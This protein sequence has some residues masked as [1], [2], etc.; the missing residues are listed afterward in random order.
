M[1]SEESNQLTDNE[2]KNI[3]KKLQIEPVDI[4]LVNVTQFINQSI[5][6]C[7][8]KD[9][10]LIDN[11]KLELDSNLITVQFLKLI[12]YLKTNN[13]YKNVAIVFIVFC[14]YFDIEYNKTYIA[15]HDKLKVL[16]NTNARKIIGESIFSKFENKCVN[17]DYK[18][19][20][21]FDL[22]KK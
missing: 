13:N 6:T 20:T 2:I 1:I 12:T 21:L 16:I 4:D 3:Y 15:L 17:P 10:L 19:T 8:D 9:F 22:F 14:D 11:K 7:F 5:S 18:V